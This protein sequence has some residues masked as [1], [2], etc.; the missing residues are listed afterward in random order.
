MTKKAMQKRDLDHYAIQSGQFDTS[1]A[2]GEQNLYEKPSRQYSAHGEFPCFESEFSSLKEVE[3][4]A[5]GFLTNEERWLFK[6]YP[7]EVKLFLIFLH[8]LHFS[9]V[10]SYSRA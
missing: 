5:M 7:D 8:Y 10:K 3:I 4:Y 6:K 9:E 2:E 1:F